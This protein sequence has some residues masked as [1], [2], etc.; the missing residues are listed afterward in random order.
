M[1][2][3]APHPETG[4]VYAR[5]HALLGT[6]R[7]M[8]TDEEPHH[9]IDTKV[10]LADDLAYELRE[11]AER[12]ERERDEARGYWRENRAEAEKAWLRLSESE[13]VRREVAEEIRPFLRE[14]LRNDHPYLVERLEA[15]AS[16]LSG[17]ENA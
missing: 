5:L 17:E 6:V 10:A 9:F 14:S 3:E 4:D 16:R 11:R 13:R 8:L 7:G 15:W 2:G 1:P 12:A